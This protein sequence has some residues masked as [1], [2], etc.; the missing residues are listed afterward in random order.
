[1]PTVFT[2]P[3]VPMAAAIGLGRRR[4]GGPMLLAG[5]VGS[6]LPDADGIAF[7]LGIEYGSLL[8]HRGF[9]HSLGFALLMGCIAL[10]FAA[11]WRVRRWQAFVWLALCTFSHP[12][13]DA[14]TNGGAAIPLL[15]PFSGERFFSPWQ[16]IEV[17]P[18]SL[19]GLM[20]GR[21]LDVLLSEARWVWL[22]L[23]A[24]AV[25]AMLARRRGSKES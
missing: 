13:L 22:P 3:A 5:M 1:M 12:V 2:H 23:L 7:R 9:T 24:A 20:S 16:P 6:V 10:P 4:I 18:V 19:Q 8:G 17:S 11:A 15:W 25:L 14:F 21:G